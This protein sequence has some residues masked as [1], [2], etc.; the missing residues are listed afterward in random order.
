MSPLPAIIVPIR[1]DALRLSR[2]FIDADH[3]PLREA[4]CARR[5]RVCDTWHREATPPW[6]GDDRAK[7]A[8]A[9]AIDYADWLRKANR[10]SPLPGLRLGLIERMSKAMPDAMRTGVVGRSESG[11][12][13][14]DRIAPQS[15]S[16]NTPKIGDVSPTR[17]PPPLRKVLVVT[18]RRVLSAVGRMIDVIA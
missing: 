10:E 5:Q 14:P 17:P 13:C 1:A 16:E 6:P 4:A 8:F 9:L 3:G 12:L 7:D 11:L 15:V 18:E 2:G